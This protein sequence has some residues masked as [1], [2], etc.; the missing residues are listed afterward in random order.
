V[1]TF[2]IVA[3]ACGDDDT[4]EAIRSG[5]GDSCVSTDDCIHNDQECLAEFKAGYCGRKDC[6]ADIDCPDG[7]ACVTEAGVNYCF[8]VCAEKV[9]CNVRRDPADEANC[10]GSA[11]FVENVANRKAC[12]PPSGT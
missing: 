12:I 8:L 1:A 5:V 11:D 9:D 2:V 10:S 3:T 7:S 4:S 6:V